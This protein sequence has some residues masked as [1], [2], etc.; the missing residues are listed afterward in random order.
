MA[1]AGSKRDCIVLCFV[2]SVWIYC[3]VQAENRFAKNGIRC[4]GVS[5]S[6][7]QHQRGAAFHSGEAGSVPEPGDAGGRSDSQPS[8][9]GFGP[10]SLVLSKAG[11]VWLRP[12]VRVLV[13]LVK[14][15]QGRSSCGF[16][17]WDVSHVHS[18]LKI[19]CSLM[20]LF[21]VT[22]RTELCSLLPDQ[23]RLKNK[24]SS[25]LVLGS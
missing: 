4:S 9:E 14:E 21:E 2:G 12:R 24:A 16:I 17:R 5:I 8:H 11:V 23:R 3:Q 25:Y 6:M 19:C 15:Q 22:R 13:S 7:C 20:P 1:A 18:D 10:R